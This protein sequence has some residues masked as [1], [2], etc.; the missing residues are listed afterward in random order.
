[1]A[2]SDESASP[3]RNA[4]YNARVEA[5][6]VSPRRATDQ[7]ELA[8]WDS[9]AR[10][11]NRSGTEHRPGSAKQICGDDKATLVD[12]VSFCRGSNASEIFSRSLCELMH[13]N[14]A[15]AATLG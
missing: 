2:A 8:A 14:E 11:F 5:H 1:M 15:M 7:L 10:W 13:A 4:P 9:I 6:R 3:S 12:C